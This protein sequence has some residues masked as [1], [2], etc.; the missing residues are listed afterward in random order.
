MEALIEGIGTAVATAENAGHRPVLVCAAQLRV[1]VRRLLATARPDLKVLSY[2]E[3][4]RSVSIEPVGVIR[5]A[6]RA[7]V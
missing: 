5:L 2:T 7:L 4:S 6:E 3:L 1:C